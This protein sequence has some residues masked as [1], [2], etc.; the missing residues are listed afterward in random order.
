ML[1]EGAKRWIWDDNTQFPQYFWQMIIAR[2]EE[3][4]KD[5]TSLLHLLKK[6]FNKFPQIIRYSFNRGNSNNEILYWSICDAETFNDHT[7][8]TWSHPYK[9]TYVHSVQSF[10]PNNIIAELE[11]NL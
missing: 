1:S 7:K 5:D 10:Y 11:L 2:S 4:S 3:I 9:C 6:T 8:Y